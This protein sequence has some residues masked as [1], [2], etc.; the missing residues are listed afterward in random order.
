M[1]SVINID[2]R[3]MTNQIWLTD[4][5]SELIKYYIDTTHNFGTNLHSSGS[6]FTKAKVAWLE[7]SGLA[8]TLRVF[9]EGKSG[10]AGWFAKWLL[11]L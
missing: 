6:L 11:R 1:N 9:F 7:G 4:F 2:K 5:K 8:E 3:I 10:K